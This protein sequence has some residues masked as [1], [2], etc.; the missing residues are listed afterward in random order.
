MPASSRG[1]HWVVSAATTYDAMGRTT[2]VTD[3]L[4]HTTTTAYTP[5]AGAP[6]GS[7]ATISVATTNTAPFGWTSTTTFDPARGTELSATDQNGKLTTAA[8][9]ALGRRTSVWLPTRPQSTNP[10]SPS[11][12]YSY[13]LSQTSASA[14]TT[15]KITGGGTVTSYSLFDGLGQ[16]VQTQGPAEGGGTDVTDTAYDSQGRTAFTDNTYWTTSV[17]PS[18]SLFVPTSLSQI[19]S[20]TVTTYDGA[21]QTVKTTLNSYGTER[22]HTSFAY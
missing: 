7:G 20:Q 11:V 21:G 9:D 10:S 19:A 18:G 17:T 4:G 12:G 1:L 14:V 22:Y 5:A 16:P 8:Y 2:Q 3:V 15:A 6:A 13:L